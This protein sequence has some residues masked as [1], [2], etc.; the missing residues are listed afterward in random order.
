MNRLS[1]GLLL[2]VPAFTGC[3]CET[4]LSDVPRP[5]AVLT[6]ADKSTP[7]EDFLKV[8]L[9]D[10]LLSESSTATMQLSNQGRAPLKVKNIVLQSDPDL[11]PHASADFAITAPT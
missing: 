8:G 10:T 3:T 2:A 9:A 6:F 11:C 1:F 4:T 5:K 7:P